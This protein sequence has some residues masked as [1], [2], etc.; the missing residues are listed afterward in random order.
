MEKLHL[1]P[2]ELDLLPFYEYEYMIEIYNDILKE[3]KDADDKNQKTYD[4]KYNMAGMQNKF[5]APNIKAPNIKLP[6]I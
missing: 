5:K 4:N 6:K 2:S 3:R 1:Q